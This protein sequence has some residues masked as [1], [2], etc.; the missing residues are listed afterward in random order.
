[1]TTLLNKLKSRKFWAA[2]IGVITG[3]AMAFG[4]DYNIINVFAGAMTAATSIVT[5]IITEGRNDYAGIISKVKE[6]A[7]PIKKGIET[8]KEIITEEDET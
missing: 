2:I 8:A 5:Y 4:L 7:E 6:N 3:I 1:M